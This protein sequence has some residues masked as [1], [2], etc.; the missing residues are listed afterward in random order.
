MS[1]HLLLFPERTIA[2][3]E[4]ASTRTT[5]SPEATVSA[6]ADGQ[7]RESHLLLY[8]ERTIEENEQNDIYRGR[9]TL[10]E[11]F[12]RAIRGT[13][14]WRVAKKVAVD[15][16][17]DPIRRGLEDPDPDF[18]WRDF[19]ERYSYRYPEEIFRDSSSERQALEK[20][21]DYDGWRRDQEAQSAHPVMNMIFYMGAFGADAAALKYVPFIGGLGGRLGGALGRTIAASRIGATTAGS[22][23]TDAVACSTAFMLETN[24]IELARTLASDYETLGENAESITIN[25]L[26]AGLLSGVPGGWRGYR[27]RATTKAFN[28]KIREVRQKNRRKSPRTAAEL[29]EKIRSPMESGME[30]S[31]EFQQEG[32]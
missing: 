8:P 10:G 22:I 14:I 24:E 21:K 16:I 12:G 23:L 9:T 5:P 28:A 3:S 25:V 30:Q 6:T 31:G 29:F 32:K 18:N 13:A 27:N 11:D 1:D 19:A 15:P 4:S 7:P 17:M 2:E 26:L 20:M